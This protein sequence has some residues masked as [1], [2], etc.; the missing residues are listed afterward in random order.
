MRVFVS[1]LNVPIGYST[2]D[3]PSL[4]WP[5]G[6]HH[7]KY[8]ESF[9]YYSIDIWTFTVAWT[10]IFF[11]IFYV[12][13]GLMSVFHNL[14]NDYRHR[15][16]I[17]K[18]SVVNSLVTVLAYVGIGLFRGFIS[19]AVIGIMLGAIYKAGSLTMSTWI[20]LSWGCAQILFDVCTS[21]STSSILL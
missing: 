13:A 9:L 18:L 10:L 4:Y 12:I 11:G 14:F 16:R 19:G 8:Q 7:Q 21:Y 3:F 15:L 20:P 5:I 6:P 2:P 1:S 17:S